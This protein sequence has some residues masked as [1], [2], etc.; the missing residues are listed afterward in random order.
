KYKPEDFEGLLNI[1]LEAVA[2]ISE[3]YALV[4]NMGAGPG[5][6]MGYPLGGGAMPYDPYGLGGPMSMQMPQPSVPSYQYGQTYSQGQSLYQMQEMQRLQRMQQ[7]IHQQMQQLQHPQS[8]A[9]QWQQYVPARLGQQGQQVQRDW[10]GGQNGR[11]NDQIQQLQ[12]VGQQI[13]RQ[14]H[15]MQPQRQQWMQQ[16]QHVQARSGQRRQQVQIGWGHGQN[17]RSNDQRQ[18]KREVYAQDRAQGLCYHCHGSGHVKRDC[19]LRTRQSVQPV[20]AAMSESAVHG[21]VV[22]VPMPRPE[23]E[24][25]PQ[26]QW[27]Y[28]SGDSS[29]IAPPC[30]DKG[31]EKRVHHKGPQINAVDSFYYCPKT[32][33]VGPD[34]VFRISSERVQARDQCVPVTVKIVDAN[35]SLAPSMAKE[36]EISTQKTVLKNTHVNE[37]RSEK[38]QT[39]LRANE[40]E[41]LAVVKTDMIT[42]D[43]NDP[44]EVVAARGNH[45]GGEWGAGAE[46][47]GDG[48]A[49]RFE[50][51][52]EPIGGVTLVELNE[53]GADTVNYDHLPPSQSGKSGTR[54]SE[55]I[56]WLAWGKTSCGRTWDPG[57]PG[58][59]GEVQSLQQP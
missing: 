12:Q 50:N 8:H 29:H 25:R 41:S 7:Q 9:Q 1:S 59:R 38:A 11:V 10:G 43:P 47:D 55:S 32:S 37:I 57:R 31:G 27:C 56:R 40:L 44:I 17:G 42:S 52:V 34:S 6:G 53:T 20:P 30:P 36:T 2:N 39:E 24:E 46:E 22:P 15:Q 51:G 54:V 21:Q 26:T 16:R 48:Q 58:V 33:S 23:Q 49:Y 13:Q 28:K 3:A 45:F 18:V 19:P 5:Q 35:E 4:A 14:R